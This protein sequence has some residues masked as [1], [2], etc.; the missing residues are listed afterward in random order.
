M[1]QPSS[2]HPRRTRPS[3]A[4]ADRPT[5]PPA[6][7]GPWPSD[8]S[9]APDPTMQAPPQSR[10]AGAASLGAPP[11]ATAAAAAAPR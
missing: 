11:P 1:A 2:S 4:L 9:T 10:A 8:Q 6:P 3:T 5:L 7:V